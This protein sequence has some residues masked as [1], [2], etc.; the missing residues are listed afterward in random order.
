[1]GEA[2]SAMIQANPSLWAEYSA[3][4]M[5]VQGELLEVRASAIL[6]SEMNSYARKNKVS[7]P[8]ALSEVC[9]SKPDLLRQY[10]EEIAIV[11]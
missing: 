9:K 4:S 7:L 5:P 1:M 11:V 10:R 2:L 6:A 3:S 8:V